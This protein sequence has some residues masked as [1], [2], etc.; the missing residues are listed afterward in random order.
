MI[1]LFTAA[2]VAVLALAPALADP[3]PMSASGT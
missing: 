3:L 2:A 1:K